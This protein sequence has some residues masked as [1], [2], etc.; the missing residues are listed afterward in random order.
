MASDNHERPPF[1]ADHVGSLLRP[2]RLTQAFRAFHQG[3]IEADAFRAAQDAAITEVVRLQEDVGLQSI[4]DGEFRR[5]S[6]WSH[7]V[8]RIEGLTIAPAR[9]Q[10][11]DEQG[12]E[13]AFTAPHV[14]GRLARR[15]GIS[16]D[17][18][19]FLK[20]ATERTPKI[21]MPSPPTMHFWRG[22][23]GI[24]RDAY[25]TVAEFFADLA[26]IYQAEI[27]ELAGLGARY[28][29]LDEVPLAMLCDPDVAA[30]LS[31]AGEDPDAL[32]DQYVAAINGALAD[33]P[34]AVT[35]AL[36][37]CRGNFK[38]RHLS[39]GGYETIAERLFREIDVDAFFLE[40]D[41]PRA[42]DFA[43]LRFVPATKRVVLGLVSSKTPELEPTDELRRRVDVAA[44]YLPLEQLCLSPQCG[45]ASTVAGN[46]LTEQDE[47]AKLRLVVET[48][49]EI[50]S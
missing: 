40:Y 25:E 10:F 39:A 11:R 48:A 20:Q 7:F 19:R 9:F 12:V 17:E 45:F 35:V 36:H 46:P 34:P 21:T 37:L 22:R 33:R 24:A 16:T 4:T 28:I 5:G 47:I 31:A 50:W 30:T 1:R 23:D 3:E 2:G 42:G 6:Y 13:T 8:E 14:T 41:T 15:D 43:P 32:V 38:G 44:E 49:A 18:F 26:A 27:A 29:Q